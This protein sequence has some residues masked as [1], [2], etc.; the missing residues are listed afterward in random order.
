MNK[1][2]TNLASLT[3]TEAAIS[4]M[5][6]ILP[7]LFLPRLPTISST[8]IIIL[9][10]FFFFFFC[11]TNKVGKCIS[12]IIMVFLW[13]CLHG[14]DLQEKIN[15]L[16][17]KQHQLEITIVS[18]PLKDK[19]GK[20]KVKINKINSVVV[21][22]PL[23][24]TWKR[25]VNRNTE[26]CAGQ[27]WKINAKLNPLHASLNDGGFDQ[28]R[29]QL[30]QRIVGVLKSKQVEALDTQCS[31]RQK[32]INQFIDKIYPLNNSGII[33]ALMFGERGLLKPEISLLLQNTGLTHLIAISGLHIGMSYLLGYLLARLLQYGLPARLITT[34]MPIL[35]GL[36]FALLYAWVSNFAIPATRAIFAL[37][38][39]VYI[40]KQPFY[41]FSWQWALWSIACLLLIDPLSILSD[42]FWLS[43]FA[44]L[45]ILYW[46]TVFPLPP[47]LS[48]RKILSKILP[49]IHLQIGLLI[50]L[51]PIQIMLF[52]GVNVMSF[53]ANLWFV[54]LVSWVIV[55]SIFGLF[56]VPIEYVQSLL[57]IFIDKV[58]TFGVQPLYILSNY[59]VEFGDISFYLLLF[60]WLGAWVILFGWYK[61]Y[62][63]L[64][65]CV[66]SLL[67][68]DIF[69]KKQIDKEW[70]LT[71]LDVG[72][73]LA[74]VIEQNNLAVLFDT[75]NRWQGESNAKRQ[76]IPFLKHHNI[77]PI[78]VIFSHNHLDHT[79]G[80][81][82]LKKHYPWLNMR[83]SFGTQYRL[84][85]NKSG[86][87]AKHLP[88]Y[89]GQ[90]WQ[91]GKLTFEALW[92][93]KL[94]KISHNDDSCV[95]Q[96]TDGYHKILLT[97]D[98]E[99][100][101]EK[102]MTALYK[103]RLRSNI[104]FAPHHG[105]NTSS[106]ALFL[107]TIKPSIALISSAR[108]SPWKIPSDKVYLRYKNNN[109]TWLNTS[110]NGQITLWFK[111][112]KIDILRYRY[113]ISP[114]WYHLWFGLPL[115]PE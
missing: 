91:W 115:F 62:I 69:N 57:L 36:L 106:T 53:F 112:E 18:I 28:Q 59:W 108:Y 66:I 102:A 67:L 90:K 43:S 30:S 21:F 52:K 107:R 105:S 110:E 58:I 97:G 83:S 49:L 15:F 76:I 32:I 24:A 88:C 45:A 61:K 73:G 93:E 96:L 7:L 113:E 16:S 12:L 47:N 81:N 35:V 25:K 17:K 109:I 46:F 104:L 27:V 92:P 75:G 31:Y 64:L 98:L 100:R 14:I 13:G 84:K 74:V 38:L 72:H 94:S 40:R 37:L 55:P 19:E 41:C 111:R 79:G 80:I 22:P 86:I 33:Y 85:K 65:G 10:C 20:L 103:T 6:G 29:Y 71:V 42:S 82:E 8:N 54:P 5:A 39:W 23:Y 78:S 34:N 70:S 4:V 77:T 63:G 56:L 2:I 1:K 3:C 101:G 89:K 114:R 87:K 51:I 68:I 44:V 11:K 26:I 50:L 48:Q 99:K 95:I 60:C 9:I